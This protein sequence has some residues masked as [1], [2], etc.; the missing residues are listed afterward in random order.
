MKKKSFAVL[1]AACVLLLTACAGQAISE[2]APGTAAEKEGALPQ[3]EYQEPAYEAVPFTEA[4]EVWAE[5]GTVLARYSWQTVRLA[6][7]N[8]DA[9]SPGDAE[10]AERNIAAF[11]EKMEAVAADL[12]QQGEDMAFYAGEDYEA[13][14]D[15][16]MEYE[17]EGAASAVFTGDILSVC[18]RRNSGGANPNRYVLG[19]LFDLASGQFILDP[20]Q[21]ADDPQAFHDGV[22]ELLIRKADSGLPGSPGYWDDYQDIIRAGR[23][24]VTLFDE[25]GMAVLYAPCELGPYAIGEVEL[26]LDWEEL[27]PLL[28]QSALARLGRQ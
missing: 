8:A 2:P 13:F 27:G 4:G 14:G 28:G 16:V 17:E 18:L 3:P 5:D 24:G 6:L 19:W 26:H 10:A 23:G 22:A 11:N 15:P 12:M 21:L 7:G 20:S 1:L 9:V 25:E